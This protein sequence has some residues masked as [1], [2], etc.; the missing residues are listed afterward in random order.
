VY[1]EESTKEIRAKIEQRVLPEIFSAM[2]RRRVEP[3]LITAQGLDSPRWSFKIS[4][5]NKQVKQLK[6][7]RIPETFGG[8][9]EA[10]E[11]F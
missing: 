5:S 8:A 7:S 11:S 4:S 2:F 3:N 10:L 9:N 6:L 1:I